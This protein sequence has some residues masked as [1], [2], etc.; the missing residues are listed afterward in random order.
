[1]RDPSR[2]PFLG[3]CAP[4]VFGSRPLRSLTHI[5][6]DAVAFA[7]VV[8]SFTNDGTLMEEVLLA[9]LILDKPKSLV[10]SQCSDRSSQD[11]LRCAVLLP[12]TP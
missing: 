11:V 10:D 8:E 6:L 9:T 7:Q 5:E 12:V 2:P 1:M 3:G 4:N